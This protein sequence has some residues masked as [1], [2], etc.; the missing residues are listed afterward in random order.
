MENRELRGPHRFHHQQQLHQH[1]H[2]S[3]D[4]PQQQQE[5]AEDV[6]LLK[7]GPWTA[8]EDALLLAYV[9]KH[10]DGNWNSVQK[11]SGVSRCGKSCRLRWT[12]H[13]RPNLKKGSL[14]PEEE[15][16]IIEQHAALGN[17]W[18]RIAAMLPGRT[19]NEIKNY[20]NTRMKR[21]LRAGLPLYPPD[22]KR[23]DT[24]QTGSEQ[25]A[26]DI[27]AS[28]SSGGDLE[29]DLNSSPAPCEFS[30]ASLPNQIGRRG[31]TCPAKPSSRTHQ[32]RLNLAE[33]R[34]RG[35]TAVDVT[36]LV[37][38][39][40]S[41]LSPSS[42]GSPIHRLKRARESQFNEVTRNTAILTAARGPF[43]Q[44]SHDS[45]SV[46]PYF[47]VQCL[48]DR[49]LVRLDAF[50]QGSPYDP[51]P[52]DVRLNTHGF[53]RGSVSFSFGANDS[54][55]S[56]ST[57]TSCP[58]PIS[59]H[60][61]LLCCLNVE[62][63]S[64]QLAES[65]DSSSG[66]SSPFASCH[67]LPLTE[68][69]SFG[70]TSKEPI[71]KNNGN[72]SDVLLQQHSPSPDQMPADMVEQ[73]VVVTSSNASPR[74][75]ATPSS[76]KSIRMVNNDP[77]YFLGG[78]SLTLLSDDLKAA[79][80]SDDSSSNTCEGSPLSVQ[81]PAGGDVP[82][83]KLKEQALPHG[84]GKTEDQGVGPYTD[85]ELFTLLTFE[86]PDGLPVS[87][88]YDPRT[89]MGTLSEQEEELVGNAGGLEA[90]FGRDVALDLEQLGAMS[91]I[92]NAWE[93]GSCVWN[94]MPGALQT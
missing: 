64:V 40:S 26:E 72:L 87:D 43:Q 23:G 71:N 5:F 20:W 49:N 94:N 25:A 4:Q 86:R 39:T 55:S 32:A 81:F 53:S 85:E 74:V 61:N 47:K 7:K 45:M 60:E 59:R 90:I 31:G 24:Q 18:S 92:S 68:V 29:G 22:V 19:D 8:E 16:L 30:L 84:S 21:H 27:T 38:N 52:P 33:L 80:K 83:L 46:Q 37:G 6:A 1:R 77:L 44:Y 15:R 50:S 35:C 93:L 10:G 76:Q 54:G 62:L 57:T 82:Q 58:F 65:A 63:P 89:G 66:L 14:A 42:L 3:Q 12:N 88:L 69:D 67:T 11:Y 36:D 51:E 13:L 91:G 73:L 75:T 9:S 78:R 17:R 70:S 34:T 48:H 2:Q 56:R 41:L 79:V 28:L